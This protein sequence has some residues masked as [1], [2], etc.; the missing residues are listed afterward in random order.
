MNHFAFPNLTTFGLPA[1]DEEFP[2][3]QLLNFPEALPTLQTVHIRIEAELLLG[4]TILPNVEISSVIQGESGYRIAPHMS[5]PSSRHASL[6]HEQDVKAQVPQEAFL[7]WNTIDPQYTA[8][9]IDKIALGIGYDEPTSELGWKYNEDF[10][11]ALEAI[12]TRPLLSNVKCLHIWDR[13]RFYNPRRL[14]SMAIKAVGLFIFV[15]PLEELI[16]AE[17]QGDPLDEECVVV[18]VGFMRSQ[19]MRGVPFKFHMRSPPAR[20]AERLEPW[21]SADRWST[22]RGSSSTE[23]LEKERVPNSVRSL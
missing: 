3:S 18:I 17:Q 11:R 23:T 9:T 22:S 6:L 5:R 12:Q 21:V 7:T 1:V 8:S 20:M 13:H 16:I 2:V 15:G 14:T 4:D 19:H 10:E